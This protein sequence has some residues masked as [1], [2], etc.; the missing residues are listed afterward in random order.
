MNYFAATPYRGNSIE[1]GLRAIG[2]CN[3]YPYRAQIAARNGING[4]IGSP[5]QN[6][7]ML[8]FLIQGLLIK[9]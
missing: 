4:Y 7:L 8:S 5:H 9:P 1:D 2:E 6:L 3:T